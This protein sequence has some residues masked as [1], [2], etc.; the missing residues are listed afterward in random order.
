[1]PQSHLPPSPSLLSPRD[2]D[3][4]A[5]LRSPSEQDSDSED[6][7][8]VRGSR[9]SIE[10]AQYDRTVLDAEDETEKLLTRSAGPTEGLRRIFS[11]SSPVGNVKIGKKERRQRRR[12]ER[13]R[14]QGRDASRESRR[15]HTSE[16]GEFLYE[17]DE[18]EDGESLIRKSEE[19]DEEEGQLEKE[20]Y[21]D[22]DQNQV[23]FSLL[24]K[25]ISIMADDG[26]KYHGSSTP[27]SSRPSSSYSL[28][29][30]SAHTK[31]P[32]TTAHPGPNHC[33][34]MARPCLRLRRFSSPSTVSAPISSIAAC[35][36]PSAHSSHGARRV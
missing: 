18:E 1:M 30:S 24:R 13:R 12:E 28:S 14:E 2:Y 35:R 31:P 11:P 10:L 22:Q 20:A 23:G 32:R 21:Q 27:W 34:P 16:N 29:S 26:S 25:G 8:F 5:S 9:T 17:M 7:Q 3:D 33:Y 15:K 36:P 6:D 19:D 4:D